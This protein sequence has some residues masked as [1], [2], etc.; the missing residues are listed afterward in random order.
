MPS[1][2]LGLIIGI[3]LASWFLVHEGLH[4][5][6]ARLQGAKARIHLRSQNPCTRVV[7]DKNP[8]N[9]QFGV[10]LYLPN[11]VGI[12]LGITLFF[13]YWLEPIGIISMIIVAWE[14]MSTVQHGSAWSQLK[15]SR[16]IEALE[17]SKMS[18]QWNV[19]SLRHL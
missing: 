9:F 8:T 12:S 14:C 16:R 18:S 13:L 6:P 17:N 5:I 7:W 11:V 10:A 15:E 2:L 3:S 4:Y 1:W 19:S